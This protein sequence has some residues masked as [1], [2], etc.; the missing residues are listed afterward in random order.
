[1]KIIPIQQ[2]IELAFEDNIVIKTTNALSQK[3]KAVPHTKYYEFMISEQ[4]CYKTL[5]IMPKA[6]G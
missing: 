3:H 4:K 6:E 2:K 1:M 5:T